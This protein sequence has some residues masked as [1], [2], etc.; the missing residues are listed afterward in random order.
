MASAPQRRAQRQQTPVEQSNPTGDRSESPSSKSIDS[1]TLFLNNPSS[2]RTDPNSEPSSQSPNQQVESTEP[3][4]CWIC[5]S[6]ETEDT[7]QNKDTWK[8]PCPCALTA[9]E[10]CLLDW[11]ADIE[12][13]QGSN[14][15]S[16]HK[17]LKCPQCK[18]DIHLARPRSLVVDLVGRA[19]KFTGRLLLPTVLGGVS[20]TLMIACSHH[21]AFAI[22]QIFGQDDADAI[23]APSPYESAVEQSLHTYVPFIA[24][25]FFRGWRGWRVEFGLPLIPA[26]LIAS[27]TRLAD[28]AL[29]LLPIMFFATHPEQNS[30]IRANLWPPSAG[31]TLVV[32]PYVRGIYKECMERVWGEREKA[33]M[34]EIHPRLGGE[35]RTD[36]ENGDHGDGNDDEEG[37]LVQ[38]EIEIQEDVADEEADGERAATPPPDVARDPAPPLEQPPTDGQEDRP[39]QGDNAQ[40]G[41]EQNENADNPQGQQAREGQQ[42]Q[43]G[44][45]QGQGQQNNEQHLHHRVDLNLL[46]YAKDFAETTVG[47]LLFPT[48]SG[49]MGEALRYALPPAWTVARTRLGRPVPS[50]LLQTQWGR[51]IVGGCLFVVMKD[52]VRIYCKWKMAQSYR[53]RRVLNFDKTKGHV[54][55]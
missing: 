38:L 28:A 46:T 15:A 45:G 52:A 7:T 32:L 49:M 42:D 54:V 48:V 53:Q 25:P 47:A 11:I 14:S 37:D 20:Y 34:K 29:P 30:Q 44:Q 33:W 24:R 26:A 43:P 10:S 51:S 8:T 6:D 1:S 50:G 12:A 22:R 5:F 13:P 4:K 41:E 19:E 9:H 16:Q 2:I 36:G 55:E 21:G 18:A 31:L 3:R 27:R 23:L 35:E 39:A 40:A 17:E